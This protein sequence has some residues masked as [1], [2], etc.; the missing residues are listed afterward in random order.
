MQSI[1]TK[2]GY[3]IDKSLYDSKIINSIKKDLNVKPIINKNYMPIKYDEN[4]KVMRDEKNNIIR[5]VESFNI[6]IE[7]DSKIILPKFYGYEKFGKTANIQNHDGVDINVPF[8]G[9]LRDIQQNI[10]NQ[11]LP[12]IKTIGGGLLSVPCGYGKTT[13]SLYL[14]HLL[15]K[16]TL[17]IVHKTFLVNQ[18][19]ERIK[20]YLPTAR[21]GIIQGDKCDII[22]KDIVIG[23][24][25]S[26]S[27]KNYESY[28]FEEFGMLIVDECHHISSKVFS[29]A[30]P[31]I[32]CK[33]TVGLSATP[34]RSDKLEKVFHWYLGPVLYK[35]EGKSKLEVMTMIYNY[36]S[37]DKKFKD[38]LNRYTKKAQIP[39]M[40]TNLTE[41]TNRNNFIIS[42]IDNL[43]KEEPNRKI[44]LLSGR[45]EHLKTL[46]NSLNNYQTGY[47]IGG[48]KE[49]DQK[50]SETKE[51]IL[52][53]YQMVSEGFDVPA[54]DTVILTTPIG[55]AEQSIGRITRKQQQDYEYTPL[56]IDIS[57]KLDGFKGMNYIRLSLY[58]KLNYDIYI[59]DTN[60]LN[61]TFIERIEPKFFIKKDEPI[62]N[63]TD[64]FIDDDDGYDT[65]N[66]TVSIKSISKP[67]K[68]QLKIKEINNDDLFIDD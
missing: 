16:K 45:V 26:I 40:V 60:E 53:T 6:Y 24:L 68:K 66:E 65:D 13:M 8:S 63:D 49:K 2:Q 18:W 4:G 19:V 52:A 59:H 27:M 23:M 10:I 38:V 20:Q 37:T 46:N 1:L 11:I 58:K 31:K 47:Y 7:N 22:D 21:I 48:M 34:N 55:N 54:L 12:K 30:L 64:L 36:K 5:D 17:V 9:K 14:S 61:T 32:N 25:Q 3:I 50:I 44:L 41:I 28:V 33:Y 39:T 67:V 15:Q 51:I 57:D 56:I 35:H 42:L 29:Q 43:K 62:N